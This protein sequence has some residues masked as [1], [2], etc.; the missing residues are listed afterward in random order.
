MLAYGDFLNLLPWLLAQLLR[1][2]F[3]F[4][5]VVAVAIVCCDVTGSS[6][7]MEVTLMGSMFGGMFAYI[8]ASLL[9]LAQ[10]LEQQRRM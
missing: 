6:N 4:F 8:W 3:V 2:S 1:A 10:D 7:A 9:L 5:G